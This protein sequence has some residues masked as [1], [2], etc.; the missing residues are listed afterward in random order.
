MYLAVSIGTT[1]ISAVCGNIPCIYFKSSVSIRDLSYVV[2][3]GVKTNDDA[4]ATCINKVR[5]TKYLLRCIV[6]MFV[7]SIQFSLHK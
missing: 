5:K 3:L 1:T 2:V 4:L 6:D 7:S